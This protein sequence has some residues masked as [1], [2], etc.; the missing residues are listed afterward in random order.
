VERGQPSERELRE[1]LGRWLERDDDRALFNLA[2]KKA[3][4]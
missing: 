3:M 4:A 2:P 1:L